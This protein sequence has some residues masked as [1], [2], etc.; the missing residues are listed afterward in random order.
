MEEQNLRQKRKVA[1][2][3]KVLADVY[4]NK[5]PKYFEFSN[6]VSFDKPKPKLSK[7]F[8]ISNKQRSQ[9]IISKQVEQM[10]KPSTEHRKDKE[11]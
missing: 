8:D 9:S 4:P 3:S 2:E 1:I 5:P 10:V 7:T 6:L 11:C